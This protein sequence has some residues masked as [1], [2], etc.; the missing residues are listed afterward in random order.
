MLES[1]TLLL[2]DGSE[3]RRAG[4]RARASRTATAGFKDAE[5]LPAGGPAEIVLGATFRLQPA[6][7][8]AIKA[9]PR[10]DPPLAPR[11]PAAGH[12]VGGVGVPQPGRGLGRPADRRAGPQGIRV[13]A[14]RSCPRST[15]TSSSTTSRAGRRTCAGVAR[16]R[17]RARSARASR[18]RAGVRGRVRRA[19]GSA[20]D[21]GDRLMAAP[22]LGHDPAETPVAVVLGGPS[23]EHD[24]SIVSGS[25][26]ADALRR[27][28]LP[29]RALAASTSTAAGG[30]SPTASARRPAAGRLRRPGGAGR[31]GTDRRPAT[32]LESLAGERPRRRSCSSRSTG[33]SARTARPRRCARRPGS[34]TRAPGVTASAVGMDKALFKRLVAR[35]RAAG[36]RLGRGPRGA[37]GARPRRRA[38][39]SSRRS[40]PA[41]ATRG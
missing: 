5:P 31:D 19:T 13:S 28:R 29:G 2:A 26:I 3:A 8:D 9:A 4:R 38:R 24:V 11:A 18:R 15:R 27:V 1:A 17:P 6:D 25:A 40:R 14:A 35:A 33:R 30:G 7:P 36:H 20:L 41:P 22:P 23:A 37:L 16:A 39:A 12:P 34:R 32:A 21:R 10:R